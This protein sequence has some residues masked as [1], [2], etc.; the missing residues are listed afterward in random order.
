[1]RRIYKYLLPNFGPL[2]AEAETL[3]PVSPEGNLSVV[4]TEWGRGPQYV[5]GLT[6]WAETWDLEERPFRIQLCGTGH[7]I[8]E[9][10]RHLST[11]RDGVYVWHAYTEQ[12]PNG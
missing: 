12:V 1:M 6:I 10:W 3:L 5:Q 9:G 8:R 11:V 4:H 7:P 2:E